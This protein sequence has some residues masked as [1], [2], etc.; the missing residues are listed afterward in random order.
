MS[1]TGPSGDVH[2]GAAVPSSEPAVLRVE[3]VF[4]DVA[5]EQADMIA[6]ELIARAHELANLPEHGCDVD[7]NV[8]RESSDAG[9]ALGV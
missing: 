3:A 4:H 5:A 9:S 1:D 7:V 8:R 2:Q 6:A